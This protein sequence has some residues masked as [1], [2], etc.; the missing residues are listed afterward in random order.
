MKQDLTIHQQWSD[1]CS[2]SCLCIE[3]NGS[4][5]GLARF[6]A[7]QHPPFL[8]KVILVQQFLS[9]EVISIA[10]CHSHHTVGNRVIIG[11]KSK[12]PSRRSIVQFFS[13]Y[14]SRRRHDG[15]LFHGEVPSRYTSKL[16]IADMMPWH[17]FLISA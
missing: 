5:Q 1:V 10:T 13:C 16:F 6:W 2:K 14:P 15:R 17:T 11:L 9:R 3:F 12:S 8:L 4:I 7:R